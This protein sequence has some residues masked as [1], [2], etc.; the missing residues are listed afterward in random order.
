MKEMVALKVMVFYWGTLGK[1]DGL[2]NSDGD[3]DGVEVGL[4]L[5]FLLEIVEGLLKV[6][7]FH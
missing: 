1:V 5:G 6:V 7:V 4:T 2:N 3:E